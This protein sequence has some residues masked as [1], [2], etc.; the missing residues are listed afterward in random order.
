M[1]TITCSDPDFDEENY[2]CHLQCERTYAFCGHR[3]VKRCYEEC[4]PCEVILGLK[5]FSY[6]HKLITKVFKLMQS[7]FIKYF[8]TISL[9]PH[10]KCGHPTPSQ[11]HVPIL[12][13]CIYPVQ[14][15]NPSFCGHEILV[16]CYLSDKLSSAD[17]SVYCRAD[18]V[19]GVTNVCGH[20][21]KGSCMRCYQGR[22]HIRCT[23]PCE[24]SLICRHL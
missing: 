2:V 19:K 4:G 23:E 22:F 10:P 8:Q 18:C 1:L 9:R 15:K 5:L 13:P 12:D 17:I 6:K 7:L 3:C 20:D 24:K 14:A 11:C 21:C 16:P